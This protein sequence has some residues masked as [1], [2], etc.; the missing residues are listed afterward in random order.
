V[1]SCTKV[2][3][4]NTNHE[5]H[6]LHTCRV[7]WPYIYGVH[8]VFLAGI[9]SNIRLCTVYIYGSGQP[10]I[11]AYMPINHGSILSSK[12]AE[13]ML[14]TSMANAGMLVDAILSMSR[15]LY[16]SLYTYIYGYM[17]IGNI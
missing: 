6:F 15:V 10:Y 3:Q 9:L 14:V 2:H 1:Q 11:H 17:L 7:G 16:D 12:R 13:L 8:T 5:L 4:T